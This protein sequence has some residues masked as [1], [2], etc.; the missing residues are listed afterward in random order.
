MEKYR[1]H[2]KRLM[3]SAGILCGVLWL[4][5]GTIVKSPNPATYVIPTEAQIQKIIAERIKAQQA[6]CPKIWDS[7]HCKQMATLVVEAEIWADVLK[8]DWVLADAYLQRN[9]IIVVVRRGNGA[10]P[11][12]GKLEIGEIENVRKV[13]VQAGKLVIEYATLEIMNLQE[14]GG[15]FFGGVGTGAILAVLIA[16]LL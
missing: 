5:C 7:N 15:W 11:L 13:Q 8:S 4:A 2:L 12:M 6:N 14:K 10:V 9:R 3:A 16:I 1:I